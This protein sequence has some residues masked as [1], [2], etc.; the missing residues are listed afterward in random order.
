MSIPRRIAARVARTHDGLF[1]WTTNAVVAAIPFSTLRMFW[2]RNAMGFVVGEGSSIL[3]GVRFAARGNFVLGRH[4]VVNN[5]CRIDNRRPVRI[6]DSVSLS[7][8]TL[9]LTDGHDMDSPKFAAAGGP[10]VIE[11]FVWT[12]ARTTISPGVTMK[13][14]SVALPGAVVVRDTE[15]FEV[16]GGVPARRVRE[17]SRELAYK[18]RWNPRVPPLG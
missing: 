5:G 9:I 11:D 4:S 18:L 8:E 7:F 12:C 2:Y 15:E 17:R 6:G 10:V 16:V 3:S 1:L 14:G 13:R